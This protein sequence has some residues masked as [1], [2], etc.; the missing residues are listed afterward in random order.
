MKRGTDTD[1]G[2][3]SKTRTLLYFSGPKCGPCKI[4][5]PILERLLK[6]T[7]VDAYKIDVD[8]C[9]ELVLSFRVRSLPTVVILN[10]GEVETQLVGLQSE[11]A[12]KKAIS[13]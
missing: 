3:M 5:E 8:D 7:G 4:Q 10:R 12:L 1:F 11:T 6:G 13:P 9:P 2:G